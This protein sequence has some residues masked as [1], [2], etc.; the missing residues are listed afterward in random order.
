LIRHFVKNTFT[1]KDFYTRRIRRIFPA[2]MIVLFIVGVMGALFLF[3][4]EYQQLAVHIGAGAGFFANLIA[5]Y[6]GQLF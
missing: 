5:L 1:F 3:P 6:R 2:L 4:D